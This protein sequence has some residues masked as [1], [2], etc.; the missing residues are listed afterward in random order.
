MREFF[1]YI[2]YRA[3]LALLAA[4]PLKAL[5][6]LGQAVGFC[7]WLILPK[8]RALAFRNTSIAFGNEK[9]R[10][11]LRRL[12]RRHFQRLGANL[13]SSVKVAVMPLDRLESRIEVEYIDI[14][15][16]VNRSWSC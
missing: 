1:L 7:A 13:L 5:F 15:A 16:P 3:G 8:Y 10:R 2:F 4:L 11:E 12:V 14:C 6:R 9:S